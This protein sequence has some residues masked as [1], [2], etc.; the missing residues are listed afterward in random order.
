MEFGFGLVFLDTVERNLSLER[1]VIALGEV[2][3]AIIGSLG[4]LLPA[5]GQNAD[6][7]LRDVE[8]RPV[9]P[10]PA[11]ATQKPAFPAKLAR[12]DLSGLEREIQAGKEHVFEFAVEAN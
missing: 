12:P 1:T 10:D 6:Y 3:A 2:S 4:L 11:S 9:I 8:M 5:Q 7:R